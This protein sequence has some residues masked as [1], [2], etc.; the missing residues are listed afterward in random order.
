M[1]QQALKGQRKNRRS[2]LAPYEEAKKSY[3]R[4]SRRYKR[5]T[6]Q[7]AK[8]QSKARRVKD[9]AALI[10]ERT[11]E[12]LFGDGVEGATEE[13]KKRLVTAVNRCTTASNGL[14]T[15]CG[16]IEAADDNEQWVSARNSLASLGTQVVDLVAEHEKI[17]ESWM[18]IQF[19]VDMTTTGSNFTK[20][21]GHIAYT[22]FTVYD[23][24][25]D[26]IDVRRAA[27]VT[28]KR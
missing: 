20:P 6:L 25:H 15:L 10:N 4:L 2:L 14:L 26:H 13:Q 23:A 19:N 28:T 8:L 16:E 1:L 7:L 9:L 17:T 3:N 18:Q 12:A 5:R 21:P 27:T 24:P 22:P 11:H